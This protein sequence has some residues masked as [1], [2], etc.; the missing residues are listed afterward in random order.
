MLSDIKQIKN[1]ENH[2]YQAIRNLKKKTFS[3]NHKY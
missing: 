1:S 3:Q 2:K